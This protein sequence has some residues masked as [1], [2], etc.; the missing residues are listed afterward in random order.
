MPKN[1]TLLLSYC[2]ETMERFEKNPTQLDDKK[3]ILCIKVLTRVLSVI[4]EPEFESFSQHYFWETWHPTAGIQ[5]GRYLIRLIM[6]LMFLPGFTIDT[7][8]PYKLV[9]SRQPEELLFD[10]VWGSGVG[11]H[12]QKG[13]TP[14]QLEACIALIR[15]LLVCMS[16]QVYYSFGLITISLLKFI[17]PHNL[18]SFQR[19]LLTVLI[20]GWMN[21]PVKLFLSEFV[22]LYLCQH[23]LFLYI[24]P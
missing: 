22:F 16:Q 13:A 20:N 18:F 1:I 6:K 19:M 21:C 3:I 7:K 24:H 11:I 12:R 9:L 2:T 14:M 8:S 5:N 17:Y 4:L 15:L 23:S 10:H